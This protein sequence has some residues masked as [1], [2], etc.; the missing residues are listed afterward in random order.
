MKIFNRMQIRYAYLAIL[1]S[2]SSSLPSSSSSLS[3]LLLLLLSRPRCHH[4]NHLCR[5]LCLGRFHHRR[6]CHPCF[7]CR[8]GLGFRYHGRQRVRVV[9][10][11]DGP[12]GRVGSGRSGSGG[13]LCNELVS[14][15]SLTNTSASIC[16]H[17]A[18]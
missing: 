2:S 14:S 15:S 5:R 1:P 12:A 3:S 8:R 17:V 4:C 7:F 6:F 11:S 10:G 18:Q 9:H 13:Q 16:V